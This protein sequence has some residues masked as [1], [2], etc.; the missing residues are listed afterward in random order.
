MPF[1]A[2]GLHAALVQATREM[3]Y[4]EPTPVQARAIPAVLAGP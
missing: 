1:R 3:R 4:S 2:L